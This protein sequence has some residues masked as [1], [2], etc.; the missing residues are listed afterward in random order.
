MSFT[1]MSSSE[2]F[3]SGID[4]NVSTISSPCPTPKI[5]TRKYNFLRQNDSIQ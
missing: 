3:A 4:A 1:F 5:F 2:R